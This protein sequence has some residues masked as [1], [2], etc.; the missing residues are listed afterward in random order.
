MPDMETSTLDQTI[1]WSSSEEEFAEKP[2]LSIRSRRTLLSRINFGDCK[3]VRRGRR[4]HSSAQ[5]VRSVEKSTHSSATISSSHFI[6]DSFENSKLSDTPAD[7]AQQKD[8]SLTDCEPFDEH[9]W[10]DNPSILNKRVNIAADC[11][12]ESTLSHHLNDSDLDLPSVINFEKKVETSPILATR[13]ARK[14]RSI[15]EKSESIKHTSMSQNVIHTPSASSPILKPSHFRRKSGLKTSKYLPPEGED[16]ATARSVTKIEVDK[17][18]MNSIKTSNSPGTAAK[19][20]FLSPPY[21]KNDTESVVSPVIGTSSKRRRKPVSMPV[22]SSISPILGSKS[23]SAR[24]PKVQTILTSPNMPQHNEEHRFSKEDSESG[25]SIPDIDKLIQF[26]DKDIDQCKKEHTPLKA[27]A[28]RSL[29]FSPQTKCD[30][31]ESYLYA[32]VVKNSATADCGMENGQTWNENESRPAEMDQDLNQSKII[33]EINTE[34]MDVSGFLS[35]TVDVPC[36]VQKKTKLSLQRNLKINCSNIKMSNR[37]PTYDALVNCNDPSAADTSNATCQ[38]VC[39]GDK[40]KKISKSCGKYK[41][42]EVEHPKVSADLKT[43]SN[44]T[45]FIEEESSEPMSLP[46]DN[47]FVSPHQLSNKPQT[48][49]LTDTRKTFK[50]GI[51]LQLIYI[52]S[53]ILYV[54]LFLFCWEFSS[55]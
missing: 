11:S 42:E 1:S 43:S 17:G 51:F 19:P 53:C 14:R 7:K 54:L 21:Q 31:N 49:S 50:S 10:D 22:D 6:P 39:K 45:L 55:Q 41:K 30:K 13:S 24:H 37:K 12:L 5:F 18:N 20:V 29:H 3:R 34:Q 44:D 47:I 52:L 40:Q 32:N 4:R 38:T 46:S 48:K 26:L 9:M 28:K 8:I 25:S 15:K 33:E 16:G 27:S 2:P 35:K 23:K 36:H